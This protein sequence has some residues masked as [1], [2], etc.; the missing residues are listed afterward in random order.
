MSK[1]LLIL[2]ILIAFAG[3]IFSQTPGAIDFSADADN[4]IPEKVYWYEFKP[5]TGWQ[6]TNCNY[7]WSTNGQTLVTTSDGNYAGSPFDK[8][9][10]IKWL[11]S[12]LNNHPDGRKVTVSLTG[13]DST[14]LIGFEDLTVNPKYLPPPT[15]QN[16][17][18]GTITSL[19][20]P[21][22]TNEITLRIE[23]IPDREFYHWELPIGWSKKG[24]PGANMFSTTS[25]TVE[26]TVA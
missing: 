17:G 7:N 9:V 23:S 4:P 6:T 13:C 24:S 21:C 5:P 14:Q 12:P 15:F 1:S 19:N 11:N 20:V 3:K 26:V 22:Y 8:R 10:Y 18:G 16:S 2:S 25:P